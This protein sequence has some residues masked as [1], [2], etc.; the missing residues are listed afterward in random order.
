[1]EHKG[2]K[3]DTEVLEGTAEQYGGAQHERKLWGAGGM[4]DGVRGVPSRQGGEET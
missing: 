3:V 1:M 2:Y 4:G